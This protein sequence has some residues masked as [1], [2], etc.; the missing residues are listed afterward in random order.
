MSGALDQRWPVLAMLRNNQGDFMSTAHA[1]ASSEQELISIAQEAVSQC[2]WTVGE[3]AAQWTVKFA[4]GRTDADFA[5]LVHLSPDQVYQRRRVWETFG[6]VRGQYPHLKWSHFYSAVAWD[7]A[8]ECLQWADEIQATV[9]EMKAWRR[10]Q[11][12]EDLSLPADDEPY[13]LLAG[14]SVAV[15][16][17][18]DGEEAPFDGAVPGNGSGVQTDPTASSFARETGDYAP[19]NAGAVTVPDKAS[20]L[21]ERVPPSAEQIF[22]RLTSTCEKFS[23]LL[24]DEVISEFQYLDGKSQR[25]LVKAFETLMEKM[26][27]IAG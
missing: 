9:A 23:A 27:P 16:M 4:K 24:S 3:C 8:A 20:S 12:G 13:M 6:D 25:R 21:D 10:A 18:I 14:E 19:F 15:R 17:P 22:K 26:Q 2:N 11:R 5:N 1:T 7:D